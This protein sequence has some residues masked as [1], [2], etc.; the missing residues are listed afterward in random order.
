MIVHGD[1]GWI[2]EDMDW[3]P[4][5]GRSRL[6]YSRKRPGEMPETHVRYVSQPT[7]PRHE[8][9]DA[10]VVNDATFTI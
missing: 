10:R 3:D 7:R 6:E 5:T 4:E 1:D 2:L 9:W 8:D